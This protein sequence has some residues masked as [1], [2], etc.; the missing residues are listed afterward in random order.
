MYACMYVCLYVIYFYIQDYT[1]NYQQGLWLQFYQLGRSL[2]LRQI[3]YLNEASD[4]ASTK[5][6]W[7]KGLLRK[8]NETV[9]IKH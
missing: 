8:L 5:W 6:E 7:Q 9:Y 2:T 1:V 3:I 4:S